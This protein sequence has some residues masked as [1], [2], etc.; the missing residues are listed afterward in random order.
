MSSL[1]HQAQVRSQVMMARLR[2][3]QDDYSSASIEV[4]ESEL[5]NHIPTHRPIGADWLLRSLLNIVLYL[6]PSSR[7]PLVDLMFEILGECSVS[8][9]PS[10]QVQRYILRSN[11]LHS[12]VYH[13]R[14]LRA[15][16]CTVG[17]IRN[18]KRPF[19]CTC[20]SSRYGT[21]L[22]STTFPVLRRTTADPKSRDRSPVLGSNDQVI[23]RQ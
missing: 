18:P 5:L 14:R 22:E 21:T 12:F 2:M 16:F 20:S 10:G 11:L 15:I 7:K 8:L 13:M 9:C 3:S 1:L 23:R 4:L 19:A 6:D 17:V